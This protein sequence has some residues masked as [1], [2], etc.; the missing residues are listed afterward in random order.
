M[1]MWSCVL[2]S[3]Q[4]ISL[5]RRARKPLRQRSML[6]G[7]TG[8]TWTNDPSLFRGVLYQLSYSAIWSRI[9]PL[10]IANIYGRDPYSSLLFLV[11][12][13]LGVEPSS[14]RVQGEHHTPQSNSDILVSIADLHR[15]RQSHD[16]LC[17]NTPFADI[18]LRRLD[19][20]QWPYP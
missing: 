8:W 10:G 4:C 13:V 3:N 11:V 2:E 19:S 5:C 7:G 14:S 15:T 6:C 18:W 16:H 12:R 1:L 17:S 9:N 20:N